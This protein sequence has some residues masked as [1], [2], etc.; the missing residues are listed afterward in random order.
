MKKQY[1]LL[2]DDEYKS[3]YKAFL[4]DRFK[5]DS[6]SSSCPGVFYQKSVAESCVATLNEEANDS[7]SHNKSMPKFSTV[8]DMVSRQYDHSI[9][10]QGIPLVKSVIKS[11]FDCIVENIGN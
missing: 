8:E 6:A 3:G 7:A 10:K 9:H 1:T 2:M 11:T 5:S 4:V